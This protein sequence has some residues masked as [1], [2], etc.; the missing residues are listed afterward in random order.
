MKKSSINAYGR[1]MGVTQESIS[2]VLKS[3]A[4]ASYDLLFYFLMS[5]GNIATVVS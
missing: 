5:D 1:E 2:G 4:D 3:V